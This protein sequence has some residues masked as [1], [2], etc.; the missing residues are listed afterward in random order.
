MG[1]LT[2]N[3]PQAEVVLKGS[4][5][6]SPQIFPQAVG[7]S[8]AAIAGSLPTFKPIVIKGQA[9]L[10]PQIFGL[11]DGNK[12]QNYEGVPASSSQSISTL[13]PGSNDGSYRPNA[14][15][16]GPTS[17]GRYTPNDGSYRPT[18]D[19]RYTPNDGQYRPSYTPN[20][21][22][23]YKRKLLQQQCVNYKMSNNIFIF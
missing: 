4:A 7:S 8:N 2:G 17:D 14:A 3:K 6:K 5:E 12:G 22:G 11:F 20:Y 16:N 15:G 1:V 21:D 23:S 18:N 19:G 13:R 10:S 9:D